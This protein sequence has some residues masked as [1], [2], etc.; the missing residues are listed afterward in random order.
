MLEN[1]NKFVRSMKMICQRNNLI[2]RLLFFFLSH[3]SGWDEKLLVFTDRPA[4]IPKQTAE[5]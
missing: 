5:T 3:K 1:K 4:I 2:D